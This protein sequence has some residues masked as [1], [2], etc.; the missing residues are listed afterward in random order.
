MKKRQRAHRVVLNF[1]LIRVLS[2][3]EA[4]RINIDGWG[5]TIMQY[6]MDAGLNKTSPRVNTITVRGEGVMLWLQGELYH[7]VD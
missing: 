1:T 4:Q 3:F 7:L 2:C 5:L 6:G